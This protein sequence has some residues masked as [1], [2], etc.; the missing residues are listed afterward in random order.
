[1]RQ[2]S[3]PFVREVVAG[4]FDRFRR[5][6]RP[7]T[8]ESLTTED[9]SPE[10]NP[11]RKTTRDESFNPNVEDPQEEP[12]V[13]RVYDFE[14]DDSM[15]LE[16]IADKAGEENYFTSQEQVEQSLAYQEGDYAPENI[17]QPVLTDFEDEDAA[18]LEEAAKD[19]AEQKEDNGGGD[20]PP[21]DKSS[22]E[23]ED[24]KPEPSDEVD[25]GVL[26]GRGDI[27]VITDAKAIAE[28]L[29]NYCQ[30]AEKASTQAT[31]QLQEILQGNQGDN[32]KT[33]IENLRP[34][35]TEKSSPD[36]SSVFDKTVD[37]LIEIFALWS[38]FVSEKK[39]QARSY[40]QILH[41][42]RRPQFR[43]P[44]WLDSLATG[45]AAETIMEN[46]RRRFDS[47]RD[48]FIDSKKPMTNPQKRD[49][50]QAIQQELD[51]AQANP[52]LVPNFLKRQD[53]GKL[54]QE[55][56]HSDTLRSQMNKTLTR[57]LYDES[58][59][60]VHTDGI[61]PE[62]IEK[63]QEHL[64]ETIRKYEA[65]NK[66]DLEA[67]P[68]IVNLLVQHYV[69][70]AKNSLQIARDFVGEKDKKLAA[71]K[72]FVR[73]AQ[74]EGPGTQ[75][76]T[77]NRSNAAAVV[78]SFIQR[79]ESLVDE[80]VG[81][82]EMVE[83]E[84]ESESYAMF[85]AYARI[86]SY[87][88]SED[89][90]YSLAALGNKWMEEHPEGS[91]TN[92]VLVEATREGDGERLLRVFDPK[93]GLGSKSVKIIGDFVKHMAAPGFT[94]ALY[95]L[96]QLTGITTESSA[97]RQAFLY[98]KDEDLDGMGDA[99][100]PISEEEQLEEKPEGAE[101]TRSELAKTLDL[102]NS[103]IDSIIKAL[104]SYQRESTDARVQGLTE[105][106][107]AKRLEA[108]SEIAE[109]L[110]Q[111]YHFKDSLIEQ[112]KAEHPEGEA[113]DN[114][115]DDEE[116][117]D[118]TANLLGFVRIAA[119]DLIRPRRIDGLINW[120]TGIKD[121]IENLQGENANYSRA[122]ARLER[123]L[124]PQRVQKLLF[125]P[126]SVDVTD[127]ASLKD[128]VDY[129][130]RFYTGST[131]VNAEDLQKLA[132]EIFAKQLSRQT[133]VDLT[134][135]DIAK[136]E[137]LNFDSGILAKFDETIEQELSEEK[138]REEHKQLAS[139]VRNEA[140]RFARQY[141]ADKGEQLIDAVLQEYSDIDRSSLFEW[142]DTTDYVKMSLL[143]KPEVFVEKVSADP[144]F[145]ERFLEH[146]F[147]PEDPDDQ[148][149]A[150]GENHPQ[151][152]PE[153][154]PKNEDGSRIEPERTDT[155]ASTSHRMVKPRIDVDR[156]NRLIALRK[157]QR[158]VRNL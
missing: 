105:E 45:T 90:A 132:L 88:F 46:R 114:L 61:P 80:F 122:I 43:L 39:K 76:P 8:P 89:F 124:D 16:E 38:S 10:E 41:K 128:H 75:P 134:A 97:E 7:P 112:Y 55:Y 104:A 67:S 119:N 70:N 53:A 72:A 4:P 142:L 22:E 23:Q 2:T 17:K 11:S 12:A 24:E 37:D 110:P 95:N 27:E 5:K 31:Q 139:K 25:M 36:E 13:E 150:L 74:E 81:E 151:D 130:R 141:V 84:G 111:L 101:D 82:F 57:L 116:D 102:G 78:Q 26:R 44:A 153:Q 51:R 120:A 99:V 109:A 148:A 131:P 156:A 123:S 62:S 33:A 14:I 54:A 133:G 59:G 157:I 91:R 92:L 106:D 34:G 1:M 73:Q 15:S 107:I 60:K 63:A 77:G 49:F 21:N 30:A 32:L 28:D 125:L 136:H 152:N 20:E 138:T 65:A 127:S 52:N 144:V 6:K 86:N 3:R 147:D 58:E 108:S 18:D 19:A 129:L 115:E 56:V 42:L 98:G 96:E 158:A 143:D 83:S 66:K 85:N 117:P 145:I 100:E 48:S 155:Q 64:R 35:A 146:N 137:E 135:E 140:A 40:G 94:E 71:L 154:T 50:N 121:A 47:A 93:T 126:S 68:Q 118:T 79:I 87:Y 149:E 113:D 103:A 9:M 69:D 29:H